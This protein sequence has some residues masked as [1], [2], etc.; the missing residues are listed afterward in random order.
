L[1]NTSYQIGSA[2]GL[3]VMTAI[4]A[5]N[6]ADRLGNPEAVTSGFS[7]AFIGA[8]VVALLG[9]ISAAIFFRGPSQDGEDPVRDTVAYVSLG[10]CAPPFGGGCYGESVPS[11]GR[12]TD[13]DELHR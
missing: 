2:V 11:R 12:R 10:F 3:A 8:A 13:H 7:A 5:P 4:A 9:A 1:V 6:G